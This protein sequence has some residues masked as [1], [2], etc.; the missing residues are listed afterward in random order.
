[1]RKQRVVAAA[2]SLLIASMV[3]T[4]PEI[5]YAEAVETAVEESTE[6]NAVSLPEEAHSIEE[7]AE[8]AKDEVTAENF[9]N[10]EESTEQEKKDRT[11]NGDSADS[12]ENAEDV[13]DA[14]NSD[15][16][17]DID[18]SNTEEK[19]ETSEEPTK[20]NESESN[21]SENDKASDDT[22]GTVNSD[23]TQTADGEKN[24]N[25]TKNDSDSQEDAA[26]APVIKVGTGSRVLQIPEVIDTHKFWQIGKYS[27]FTTQESGIYEEMDTESK[28]VG[29]INVGGL[30]YRLKEESDWLYVESGEVR[31]FIPQDVL[32]TDDVSAAYKE[33]VW[34]TFGATTDEAQAT[35]DWE[36]YYAIVDVPYY[37]NTAYTYYRATTKQ[38]VIEKNYALVQADTYLN[39]RNSASVDGAVVGQADPGALLY[40]IAEE[41]SDWIYIESGEVRGFVCAEYVSRGT[42]IDEEVQ[43]NG[44]ESYCTAKSTAS[45]ENN[46]AYYYSLQT[47]ESGD[48]GEDMGKSIVEY[49]KN[50]VGNAYVWGGTD[51]VNGADCSGFVQSVYAMYGIVLPRVAE[52]QAQVGMAI[53][54]EYARPGDLVFYQDAAG[55]IYHVAIYAGD[56]RTVEA[57]STEQGIIEG[58]VNT[59]ELAWCV[60]VLD[61]NSLSKKTSDTGAMT[62]TPTEIVG[63]VCTYEKWNTNWV[64]GT[65]QKALHEL[66]EN[67]DKE[68]FGM[69]GDRYVIAC[70]TTYGRVGDMIDFELADGTVVK[71]I[72]G[73]TKN[74]SD[75]GCNLYGHLQG[76]NVLEFLVNRELWYPNHANP[77][78]EVCHPELGQTVVQVINYGNILV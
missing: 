75:D 14:Y 17:E 67:Y 20:R 63:G 58:M 38:V 24:S 25:D 62:V 7:S 65:A 35:F 33:T 9:T 32:M 37:E 29:H 45:V 13:D 12:L 34:N 51:L 8:T 74:Q 49:A 55:Y 54:Y 47:V 27:F 2:V 23:I 78:T 31:G 56:G 64:A 59:A 69:I 77:G 6:N 46:T 57:F 19:S 22:D 40:V 39:V 52:N 21:N 11:D 53:A 61:D 1:M 43:A 48:P 76:Q 10:Q 28:Q 72:I 41:D 5:T 30:V 71:T 60:R 16:T 26:S 3:L 70:T 42:K 73:D 66:Y 36:P 18:D 44:E 15:C 4:T 50:Y 68:G